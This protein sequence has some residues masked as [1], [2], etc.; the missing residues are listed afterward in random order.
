MK[1][2]LERISG[3]QLTFGVICFMQATMMR[4]AFV[5]SVTGIDSWAMAFTG[6]LAHLPMLLGFIALTR[7]FPEKNLF[8]INNTVFGPVVGR[9]ISFIYLFFF[10]TLS[11]LNG[12]DACYFVAD[13]MMPGTALPIV[14]ITL[15]VACG[16]GVRRGLEGFMR[17]GPLL[18]IGATAVV[19]LNFLLVA[20]DTHIDYLLP[21]FDQPFIKYVQGTH[22]TSTIPFG[23]VVV[24]MMI[25]PMMG[26]EKDAGKPLLLSLLLSALFMAGIIFRDVICLGPLITHMSLPSFEAVRMVS[27]AAVITRIE[28]LYAIVNI[29]LLYFKLCVLLYA[30]AKGLAQIA[31]LKQ[32]RPLVLPMCALVCAYGLTIYDSAVRHGYSGSFVAPFLWL[33]FE[34]ALPCLTLLVAAIRRGRT[35]KVGERA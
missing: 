27:L 7:W 2:K 12:M 23:E 34:Y 14:M 21:M 9:L 6:A 10:L 20:K 26:R 3:F 11:G 19:L 35:Q 17:L 30:C 29:S 13:F 15:L 28:S 31:G 4:S 5:S 25:A 33:I 18:S 32:Y 1:I 22:I 8:E 16:Y 24:F